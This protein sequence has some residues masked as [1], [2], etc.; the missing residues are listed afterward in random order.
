MLIHKAIEFATL[1]HKEQL[2]KATLPVIEFQ[3]KY[4][5]RI[6]VGEFSAVR[7]APDGSAYRYI[8]DCIELFEE[9]KWDWTY[10][11]FRSFEGWNLEVGSDRKNKNYSEKQTDREKLLREWFSKNRKDEVQ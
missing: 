2:R 4:A 6:F 7:W 5:A 1:A 3:K 10:H 8:K 11:A 9:Y